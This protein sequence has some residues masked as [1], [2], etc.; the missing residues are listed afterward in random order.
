MTLPV[1]YSFRRC[2]YAMRA[3]L[4]LLATQCAVELREVVLRNKPE[5]LLAASPKGTVPVLI[6]PDGAV[7]DE[8]RDIMA[9]AFAQRS[10]HP[11]ARV[12]DSLLQDWLDDNDQQFKH[13]LD[14]YKYADRYPDQSA[15]Y[16]REH[17]EQFLAR[18]EAQLK[19]SAGE[20]LLGA[21]PSWLDLGV[22]PFVRQFAHVD[23]T[24]FDH[25]PY[26]HVRRWLDHWLAAS[27][28][29]QCMKKYTPWV[30]GAPPEVFGR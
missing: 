6:L 20:Y 10:D 26:H 29:L 17:G 16:Y 28:F 14:R 5:A 25:S 9:W 21:D 8:S 11:M 22:M 24:W 7:I 19:Q 18:L 23:R 15:A 30:P 3:R 1:L 12:A 4:A 2:P 27:L 13:W